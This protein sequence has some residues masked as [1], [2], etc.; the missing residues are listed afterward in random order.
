MKYMIIASLLIAHAWAQDMA[1]NIATFDSGFGGFFTAKEI[2]K[3]GHKLGSAYRTQFTITHYGDTAHAPYGE[4]TPDQIAEFAAKGISKAIAQ[5]ADEVFLACNTASTQFEA[6]KAILNSEKP[7]QGEK[8]T[9]ILETSTQEMKRL[10]DE[11]LKTQQTVRVAILATPF[12]VKNMVYPKALAAAYQLQFPDTQYASFQQPRWLSGRGQTIDNITSFTLLSL[13]IGRQIEI[14]QLGPA[15]W[16]EMIEFGAPEEIKLKQ[17]KSDL[18]FL[19]TSHSFDVVGEFC[20]HYPVFDQYIQ[21]EALSTK[22]GSAETQYITQGPL[23]AKLFRKKMLIKLKKF[24]RLTPANSE[25]MQSIKEKSRPIIFISG[26]N[27]KETT[28]LGR[29]VFPLD[30]VPTVK[31]ENF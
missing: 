29:V 11:K 22:I 6:I 9:S 24:K 20:T 31:Q 26:D 1:L 2:E 17:I 21:N 19:K 28:D 25:I 13:S 15:N 14:Y 3:E 5:G 23:M 8:V 27:V 7:G 4:K 18:A 10:I 30:P 16:V 12:T